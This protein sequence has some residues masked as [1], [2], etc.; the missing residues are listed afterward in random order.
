M[1]DDDEVAADVAA[2]VFISL[3]V[4]TSLSLPLLC[5]VGKNVVSAEPLDVLGESLLCLERGLVACVRWAVDR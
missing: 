3:G 2:L 5:L 4:C 1:V